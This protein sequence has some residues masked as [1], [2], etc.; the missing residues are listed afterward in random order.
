MKKIL[1]LTLLFLINF[2]GN[3]QETNLETD[4]IY[5][6]VQEKASPANG[7]LD[8]YQ[9][10]ANEFNL[11]AAPLTQP[12][13]QLRVKFVV[14]KDG[15]ITNVESVGDETVF[16]NE[17][18]RVLTIMPNWIPAKHN[19]QTVRSRF[20]LPIKLKKPKELVSNETRKAE[21]KEGFQLFFHEFA[22]QF[23]YDKKAIRKAKANELNFRLVFN[24]EKDGSFSSIRVVEDEYNIGQ[25]AVRVMQLMPNWNPAMHNGVIVRSTFKLPIK[26]KV[27]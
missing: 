9:T 5:S 10:F 17:V 13:L 16:L 18:K 11:N 22:R 2:K 19:G 21:P 24:I 15:S 14:E 12:D 23:K 27:N 8:F 6:L 7:M 4:K 1:I 3:A 26:I 25:E 20:I